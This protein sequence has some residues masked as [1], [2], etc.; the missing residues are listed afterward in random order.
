MEQ[1][2][3]QEF[4]F[5][6]SELDI[7]HAFLDIAG[8]KPLTHLISKARLGYEH[9]LLWI[10]TVHDSTKLG[11]INAKLDRLRERLSSNLYSASPQTGFVSVH[12]NG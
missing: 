2:R 6:E 8:P 12:R 10:G 7:C 9:V 5:F 4:K 11:R 3:E 1:D